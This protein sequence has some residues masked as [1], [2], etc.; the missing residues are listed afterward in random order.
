MIVRTDTVD[1]FAAVEDAEFYLEPWAVTEKDAVAYDSE[2]RLLV[3]K[4]VKTPHSPNMLARALGLGT[5]AVKAVRI[6]SGEDE[7]GHVPH[8]RNVL[9]DLLRRYADETQYDLERLSV[10]N[11]VRRSVEYLGL[12]R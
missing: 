8:L 2:G 1:I 7:P 9:E 3:L 11:L 4:V 5:R 10:R 6:T 12:T